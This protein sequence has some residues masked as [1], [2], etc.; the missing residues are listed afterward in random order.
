[1]KCPKHTKQEVGRAEI[2]PAVPIAGQKFLQYF[3]GYL[4][5]LRYFKFLFFILWFLA[6]P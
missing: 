3:E 4:E 2:I 5:V 6:E 1:M